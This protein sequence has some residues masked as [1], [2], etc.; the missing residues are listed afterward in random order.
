MIRVKSAGVERKLNTPFLNYL[1][2]YT[3]EIHN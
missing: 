1:Y 3:N 2:E